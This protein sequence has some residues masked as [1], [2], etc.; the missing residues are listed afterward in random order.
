[1]LLFLVGWGR[2]QLVSLKGR[3][4]GGVSTEYIILIWLLIASLSLKHIEGWVGENLIGPPFW[5]V[6]TPVAST[7]PEHHG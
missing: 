4:V 7:K 5:S 2:A 6:T 3:G 1:M